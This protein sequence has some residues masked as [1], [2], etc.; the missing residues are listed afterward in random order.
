MISTLVVAVS[1]SYWVFC[2][3]RFT[4]GICITGIY[5]TAFVLGMTVEFSEIR[6]QKCLTCQIWLK[7]MMT[8]VKVLFTFSEFWTYNIPIF[9]IR[10]IPVKKAPLCS[11]R[12]MKGGAFLY[13][14]FRPPKIDQNRPKNDFFSAAGE[15]FWRLRR[16]KAPETHFL[17]DFPFVEHRKTS[18]LSA[19]GEL[20]E[21]VLTL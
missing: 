13:G 19:C 4:I 8:K 17:H 2:T 9:E 1:P 18:K 10:G 15:K 11:G 21:N 16:P 3:V 6:P 14:I 12:N 20:D 7:L 5:V